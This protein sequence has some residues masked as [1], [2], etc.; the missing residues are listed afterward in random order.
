MALAPQREIRS[1]TIKRALKNFFV[2]VV[3]R[4]YG[5][6]AIRALWETESDGDSAIATHLIAV[7]RMQLHHVVKDLPDVHGFVS[8]ITAMAPL[9][10]AVRFEYIFFFT[11]STV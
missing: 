3:E 7:K 1:S 11:F 9:R 10:K 5:V 8:C 4:Y 6:I 2:P